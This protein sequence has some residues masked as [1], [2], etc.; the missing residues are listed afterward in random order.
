MPSDDGT[1]VLDSAFCIDERM[2]NRGSSTKLTSNSTM[3][4]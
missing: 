2:I 4:C 3:S 1:G